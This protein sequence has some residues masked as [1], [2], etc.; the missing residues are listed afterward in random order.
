MSA[1]PKLFRTTTFRLSM[2]F[3]A[4]FAIAGGLA[5]AYIYWNTNV[6]FARQLEQTIQAEIQGL[7]EQYSQGGIARLTATIAERSQQPGNSLYLV[8]DAS[9]RG[10][11]G[12]LQSVS[13]TLWDTLG[14]V[15]FVYRR[16][17]ESGAESRLAF[18]SV[19]RLSGGFRL[20]VGRDIEDRRLLSNIVRSALLWGLAFMAFVSVVGGWLVSRNILS[21]ID[22]VTATSRTIMSGDLSE[23]IPLTGSGDELDRLSQNLNEMLERI[24]Q[25]MMGLKEV[26]DNIAHDLKTPLN[27]LR[28]RVESALRSAESESDYRLTLQQTIEDADILIRTF[29]SLLSIARL[30][31]G[32]AR[33]SAERVAA[34]DI[35]R[36][37]IEL[38]EPLAVDHHMTLDARHDE[39]V[40]LMVDRQLIGQA[41]ANLIDNAIKYTSGADKGRGSASDRA[42]RSSILVEI[43]RQGERAEISV[44]D[45]GPGIPEG[46]RERVLKRFVRLEKSRSQAG[47]GLGLSLVAA[48]ARLYGGSIKFEDNNPGLRAIL[49]LPIADSLDKPSRSEKLSGDENARTSKMPR[50]EAQSAASKSR[51][52]AGNEAAFGKVEGAN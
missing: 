14:R 33:K 36:D 34:A 26:S 32:A 51:E 16:P 49:T 19:F 12:N 18:A 42:D 44:A 23:R 21:R 25:L 41:L 8:T 31:A 50:A 27:R 20:I 39:T 6:L 45:S 37:V 9:G 10:I 48:V 30:E 46:D 22:M 3:F 11:A 13:R 52:R 47:S 38:Y 24:E 29:N 15:E 35:V 7:A 1:L 40:E 2:S 28:N 17:G 43:T 5:I 4:L